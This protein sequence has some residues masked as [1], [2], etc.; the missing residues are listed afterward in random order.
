[1]KWIRK[2][3][4]AKKYNVSPA[5]VCKLVKSGKLP[6][7]I[8]RGW[9]FVDGNCKILPTPRTYHLARVHGHALAVNVGYPISLYIAVKA[10]GVDFQNVPDKA[11]SG[12]PGEKKPKSININEALEYT[13]LTR[14]TLFRA[15]R[16]GKIK[17]YKVG[18]SRNSPVIVDRD[19]LDQYLASCGH[20]K[21]KPRKS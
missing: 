18:E 4:Y 12:K 16:A 17:S 9:Q 10:Y 3:E 21:Y 2:S 15:I 7:K 11:S 6:T 5:Y 20:T 14:W 8:L 1:M 13:G 19:S